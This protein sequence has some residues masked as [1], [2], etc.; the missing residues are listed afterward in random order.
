[1]LKSAASIQPGMY[2]LTAAVAVMW[3][4]EAH[5][6]CTMTPRAVITCK[7]AAQAPHVQGV[8]IVLKVHQQ[9]WALEVA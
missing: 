5:T 8:V 3:V 4:A 6:L 2:C 7:H 1:M 9:L